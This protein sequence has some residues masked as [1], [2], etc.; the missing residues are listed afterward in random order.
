MS[1]LRAALDQF[2]QL[3]ADYKSQLEHYRNES[4]DLHNRLRK[5]DDVM[6]SKLKESIHEVNDVRLSLHILNSRETMKTKRILFCV[7]ATS[8][9]LKQRRVLAGYDWQM[10]CKHPKMC[11]I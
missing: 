9:T 4:N 1:K 3:T 11:G 7:N 2:E 5:Q 10:L 8:T 6:N